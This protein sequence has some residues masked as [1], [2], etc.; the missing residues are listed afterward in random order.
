[1]M[2]KNSS[3]RL[4]AGREALKILVAHEHSDFRVM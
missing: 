1:M 4:Q 2:G 3:V